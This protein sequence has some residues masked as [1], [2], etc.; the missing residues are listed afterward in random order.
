MLRGEWTQNLD[1]KSGANCGCCSAYVI[2]G[3]GPYSKG[4][5]KPTGAIV[6]R[7][8]GHR[9]N[10]QEVR[11]AFL[12]LLLCP[13]FKMMDYVLK[14]MNSVLTMMDY[15]LTMMDYVL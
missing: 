2:R 11:Y 9:E 5:D 10:T 14:M 8:S 12:C 15:V 7:V 13:V 1:P 6:R 3:L 4:R